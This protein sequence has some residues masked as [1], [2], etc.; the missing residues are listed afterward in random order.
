[1]RKREEPALKFRVANVSDAKLELFI[2]SRDEYRV[3]NLNVSFPGGF[4]SLTHSG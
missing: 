1:M 4:A 3:K 2:D